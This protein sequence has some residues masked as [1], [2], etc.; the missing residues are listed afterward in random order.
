MKDFYALKV[1]AIWRQFK[2]EG[3]AF[4]MI[5]GY[6][7]I[8]YVRPQAIIPEL[9]ILPWGKLFVILAFVGWIFQ[10]ERIWVSSGINILMVLFFCCILASC[11]FSYWP[12]LSYGFL[13]EYYLWLIIYFLIIN[14]VN[15]RKRFVIFLLIFLVAS[16]KL[17][18]SLARIWAFRGFGF[19]S[20]GLKGPPGYFENSGELAIQM[21]IFWPI[22]L[23]FAISLK[24]RISRGKFALLAAMPLTAMATIVG[25][26]S[27]GGQLAMLVQLVGQFYKKLFRIK[28][29]LALGLILVLGWNILPNEQQ[30]RMLE[31]GQDIS[32]QQRLLYWSHGIDMIAD[33][34]FFGVGFFN[35]VPYYNQNYSDDLLVSEAQLAHNIFIQVGADLGLVGLTCYMALVVGAFIT[36][37]SAAKTANRNGQDDRLFEALARAFNWS[38]L[39]FL[40][41]GQF[42][43]VVYYPFMWI[44]MAMVVALRNI[45]RNSN[46]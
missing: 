20:W 2:T 40:I 7:F 33:H 26:S 22:A 25:A 21:A 23:A 30:T 45:V 9:D 13:S 36:A 18:F 39:G 46:Q 32:S 28:T 4:W 27:R 44:H 43:S 8:E 34:P 15:T 31:M 37:G 5:C 12:N 19:A 29:I 17:S 3:F 42:V 1:G 14:I 24:P 41:A 10:R 38:F 35:F 16:A 6:L 11:Y